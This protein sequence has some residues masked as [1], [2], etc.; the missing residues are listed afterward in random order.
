MIPQTK[1]QTETARSI[2]DKDLALLR[3]KVTS[4]AVL[5][6]GERRYLERLV[7]DGEMMKTYCR[8]GLRAVAELKAKGL[9]NKCAGKLRELEKEIKELADAVDAG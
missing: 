2:L 1:A 8:G 6:V 7:S 5:R 4:G 3:D 9:C